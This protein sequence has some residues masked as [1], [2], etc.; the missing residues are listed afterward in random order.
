M[1]DSMLP[2]P[3]GICYPNSSPMMK[4]PFML[5]DSASSIWSIMLFCLVPKLL[6]SLMLVDEHLLNGRF[7]TPILDISKLIGQGGGGGRRIPQ[8]P[9]EGFAKRVETVNG[10]LRIEGHFN[11]R[12]VLFVQ[13]KNSASMPGEGG[14]VGSSDF[15]HNLHK[16]V[17][18]RLKLA[19]VLR[20]TNTSSR[21]L[22]IG[23][24]T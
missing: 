15:K 18:K 5:G 4:L 2:G 6:F 13:R 3:N 8:V 24:L 19:V 12:R 22:K 21:L 16:N 11:Q 10:P 7:T 14:G 1:P 23:G 9:V 20:T 17:P